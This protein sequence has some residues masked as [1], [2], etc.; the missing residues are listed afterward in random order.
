MFG[1]W[2]R[3]VIVCNRHRIASFPSSAQA[4]AFLEARRRAYPFNDYYVE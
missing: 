3:Y 1:H 4:G 2:H